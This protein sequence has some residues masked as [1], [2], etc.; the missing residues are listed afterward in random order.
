MRYQPVFD[1]ETGQTYLPVSQRGRKTLGE[2][3]LNKGTAFPLDE[4]LTLGLAGLLPAHMSTQEQ[5]MSRCLAQLRAKDTSLQKH[6]YLAS[7]HDRNETL[8]YRVVV[9][10]LEETVPLIY[11]PT[12]AEAC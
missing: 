7:L 8:F 1:S 2:P 11:T 6:I 4:R 12:V 5:Q 3:L 10:N 9:E